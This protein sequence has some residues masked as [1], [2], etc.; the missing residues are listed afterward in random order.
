M[1]PHVPACPNSLSGMRYCSGPAQYACDIMISGCDSRYQSKWSLAPFSSL[2]KPAVEPALKTANNKTNMPVI[3][4]N[5]KDMRYSQ[6]SCH[7]QHKITGSCASIDGAQLGNPEFAPEFLAVAESGP[8][9][10]TESY[11][12][13]EDSSCK[14]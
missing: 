2:V 7:G 14:A 10:H 9:R 11:D 5:E 1:V 4:A 3:D 8:H 12:V 13:C 6:Q